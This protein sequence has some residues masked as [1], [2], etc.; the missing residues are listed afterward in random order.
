M[1]F[2]NP[3][4]SFSQAMPMMMMAPPAIPPPAMAQP[5]AR[6]RFQDE[7]EEPWQGEGDPWQWGRDPEPYDP[8]I[9]AAA[10]PAGVPVPEMVRPQ[11]VGTIQGPA[12][13]PTKGGG[14]E[15]S[16]DPEGP[17]VRRARLEQERDQA[18]QQYEQR[19]LEY[20][21][22]RNQA[23]GKP[24]DEGLRAQLEAK[25]KELGQSTEQYKKLRESAAVL[26]QQEVAQRKHQ[27]AERRRQEAERKAAEREEQRRQMKEQALDG[28]LARGSGD[29]RTQRAVDRPGSNNPRSVREFNAQQRARRKARKAKKAKK[30]RKAR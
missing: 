4:A 7:P 22:L 25:K 9:A 19:R 2:T 11:G 29:S 1:L 23:Q 5:L 14:A 26:H 24:G 6:P 27:E 3:W 16:G 8:V 20:R 12:G 30:A 28:A 17:R 15:Q 18:K 10:Q 13:I 21:Q